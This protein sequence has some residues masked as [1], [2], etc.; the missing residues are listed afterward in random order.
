MAVPYQPVVVRGRRFTHVR[1]LNAERMRA[2]ANEDL[3]T[4]DD[5]IWETGDRLVTRGVLCAEARMSVS[6]A[7][8]LERNGVIV[9]EFH[10]GRSGRFLLLKNLKR[11]KDETK[12]N[13]NVIV[14]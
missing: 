10:I 6:T 14:K 12:R 4:M 5:F 3:C 8:R 1:D 2:L 13:P 7:Y 9:P 11:L